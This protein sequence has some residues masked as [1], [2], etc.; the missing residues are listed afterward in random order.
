MVAKLEKYILLLS[1]GDKPTYTI[2]KGMN[3]VSSHFGALADEAE[4]RMQLP[5]GYTHTG[6]SVL[7]LTSSKNASEKWGKEKVSGN[8]P[9]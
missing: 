1:F 9:V 5:T 3:L 4:L 8:F 7:H 6:L 2:S